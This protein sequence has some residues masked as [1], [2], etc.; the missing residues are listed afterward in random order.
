MGA[1]GN[2][3]YFMTFRAKNVFGSAGNRT[4]GLRDDAGKLLFVLRPLN[5][6]AP[7]TSDHRRPVLTEDA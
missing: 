2:P 5:P 1:V 4:E 6:D 7:K 3:V